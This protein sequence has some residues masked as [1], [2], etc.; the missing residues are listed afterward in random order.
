MF[1]IV[2]IMVTGG[3]VATAAYFS[4]AGIASIFAYNYLAAMILGI[5]LEAGKISVA[6]YLY[7]FWAL[8]PLLF[9][10][11]LISF[12]ALL[13]FITS[14]GIFGFLSQGYQKTSEEH[15]VLL[16]ELSNLEQEYEVK[17]QRTVSLNSQIQQLPGNDVMGRIRLSREFGY[18][19]E[20]IRDR[21]AVIEPRIQQLKLKSLSYE[22]Q[23]GP[24]SYVAKMLNTPQDSIVFYAIL[25]LV[26]VADP[27]AVTLTVA[28]NMALL[29]FLDHPRPSRAKTVPK[30]K[31][32]ASMVAN[33]VRKLREMAVQT[34]KGIKSKTKAKPNR[35][36]I[37]SGKPAVAVKR[38]PSGR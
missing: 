13:M 24:I 36:K 21:L 2:L 25:M 27:L 9:K 19:Q 10:S 29:R 22:S 3:L 20:E 6:V 18:E 1:I 15:R 34:H 7:R 37:I 31:R 16:L 30:G 28:C 17:K 4:V 33:A 12:M 23:I 8:L 5:S 35:R 14:V 26:F 32:I 38:L 11:I